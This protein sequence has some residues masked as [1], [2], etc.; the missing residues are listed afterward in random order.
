MTPSSVE[1]SRTKINFAESKYLQEKIN[2]TLEGILQ[3]APSKDIFPL[4]SHMNLQMYFQLIKN[5][6]DSSCKKT[7][8]DLFFFSLF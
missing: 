8:P 7:R 2:K 6:R 3:G 1:S 5:S 4:T